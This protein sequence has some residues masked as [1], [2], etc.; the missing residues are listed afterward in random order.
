MEVAGPLGTPLGLAQRKR[1]AWW[2]RASGQGSLWSRAAGRSPRAGSLGGRAG[3]GSCPLRSSGILSPL[4]QPQ[5]VHTT[6]G[7]S[8]L[9]GGWGS[10]PQEQPRPGPQRPWVRG[11]P[12]PCPPSQARRTGLVLTSRTNP[13]PT[14]GLHT[15]GA[16]ADLASGPLI[17]GASLPSQLATAP[18]D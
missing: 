15:P 4:L 13:T 7:A 14:G 11:A 8:S 9:K 12:S 1:A 18:E 17:L 6:H 16:Q 3:V 2:S 10:C 5:A